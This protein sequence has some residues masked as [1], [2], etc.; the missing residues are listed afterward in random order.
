MWAALKRE[1]LKEKMFVSGADQ[2]ARLWAPVFEKKECPYPVEV[3]A[4]K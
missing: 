1:F 2:G 4:K 3:E